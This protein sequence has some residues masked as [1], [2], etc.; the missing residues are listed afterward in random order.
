[1]QWVGC[2]CHLQ[3]F[4]RACFVLANRV[5][6]FHFLQHRHTGA[7][8]V[9]RMAALPDAGRLFNNGNIV[10]VLGEPPGQCRS[11]RAGYSGENTVVSTTN[12]LVNCNK[13]QQLL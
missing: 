6:Q 5:D 2:V 9:N 8:K 4:A 7:A 11:G 12:K 13:L 10:S 3:N 1:M